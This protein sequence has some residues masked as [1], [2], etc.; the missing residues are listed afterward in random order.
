M[1]WLSVHFRNVFGTF[2][3]SRLWIL[4][5]LLVL[6]QP[7]QTV[8]GGLPGYW[9]CVDGAWVAHG[10]P[11]HPMPLAS[12][13]TTAGPVILT[14]AAGAAKG[15][16]WGPVGIFPQEICVLP[17][18]D[19]GRF[20]GDEGECEGTCVAELTPDEKK[21]VLRGEPVPSAGACTSAVPAFGC[22]AIVERGFVNG[23]LC[24]D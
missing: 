24:L 16:N 5:A 10:R 6:A 18:V 15:G 3:V 22:M 2:G 13:G 19:A 9:S 12:C 7:G 20:C 11:E 1:T 23:I 4:T 14:E 8:A 17:T 21:R